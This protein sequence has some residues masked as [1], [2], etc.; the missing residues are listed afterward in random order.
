MLINP[1]SLS[2]S[3]FGDHAQQNSVGLVNCAQRGTFAMVPDFV[4][5]CF[6]NFKTRIEYLVDCGLWDL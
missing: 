2:N 4:K 6:V 3:L 5:S 1:V